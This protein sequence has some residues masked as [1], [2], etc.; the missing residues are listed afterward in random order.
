MLMI[1]SMY[2]VNFWESILYQ[3]GEHALICNNVP[4]NPTNT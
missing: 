2:D 1:I 4:H 3:E